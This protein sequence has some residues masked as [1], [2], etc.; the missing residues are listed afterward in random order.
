MS[1]KRKG[2]ALK[3]ITHAEFEAQVVQLAAACGYLAYHTRDSRG[4]Q[5][6]FPD[7]VLVSAA[8][9][10]C[11]FVELKVPPDGPS[12]EQQA[13]LAEL[14]GAGQEAFLWYPDDFDEAVRVLMGDRGGQS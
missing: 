5:K 3:P 12:P 10:R 1:K 13:W 7:W 4:S 11:L 8:R 14:R 2:P 6:G 9:K